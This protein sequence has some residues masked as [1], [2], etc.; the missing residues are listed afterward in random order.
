MA[1]VLVSERHFYHRGTENTEKKG[2]KKN[3]F[4]SAISAALGEKISRRVAEEQRE[5]A[6]TFALRSSC[7]AKHGSD[8]GYQ[9]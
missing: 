4:F 9:G 3:S 6:A 8:H 7:P 1:G 2:R 5:P